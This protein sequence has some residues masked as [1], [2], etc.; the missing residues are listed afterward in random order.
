MA[1]ATLVVDLIL[2][3]GGFESDMGRA[4][5]T[6]K[7]RLREIETAAKQAGKVIGG[8][9]IVGAGLAAAAMKSAIDRADEL[10]NSS[11]KLGVT[12]EALST[13]SY[14]AKQ[15]DLEFSDLE[16]AMVRLAK[17]QSEADKG[18]D[19]QVGLFKALGVEFRNADGSLRNTADLIRE[20]AVVLADLPN[21]ADKAAVMVDLFGKTG[22]A[23]IPFITNLS[24]A[25]QR[26]RDLGL[27]VSGE[28]AAAADQFKDLLGDLTSMTGGL[29]SEIAAE[30]LPSLI[31]MVEKFV[32]FVSKGSGIKT[33]AFNIATGIRFVGDAALATTDLIN[34]LV[35]G[36]MYLWAK[37]A[38]F[39]HRMARNAIP[40]VKMLGIGDDALGDYASQAEAAK[41][42]M[43]DALAAASGRFEFTADLTTPFPKPGAGG[44]ESET[45]SKIQAW[46]QEQKEADA[47]KA[48]AK[49]AS[50]AAREAARAAKEAER[51]RLE[52]A[53]EGIAAQESLLGIWQSQTSELGGPLQQ[54]AQEYADQMLNILMAEEKLIAAGQMDEVQTVRLIEARE[55][56]AE[57][58]EKNKKAIEDQLS[59]GE[60]LL[61]QLEFELALMRMGNAERMTAIQLRGLEADEVAKFGA[62]IKS[63]NEE[64]VRIE[65]YDN[66]REAVANA[67]SEGFRSGSVKDAIESFASALHNAISDRLAGDITDWLLGPP[68]S[69]SG[70]SAGGGFLS[71]LSSL[72]GGGKAHGGPVSGSKFYEVGENNRPEMFYSGGKSFLIPGNEGRVAPIGGGGGGPINVNYN[73]RVDARTPLQTANEIDRRQRLAATRNY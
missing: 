44:G 58:Y 52:I 72:W 30:L 35:N 38:E 42:G 33:A 14:A 32:D 2:K 6:A 59:P 55:H 16:G 22:A 23:L 63:K 73:R 50:E 70:G 34:G 9:F 49:A 29:A 15:A 1:L 11:L 39:G 71:W 8:A 53:K 10:H 17:A 60:E 12:A 43:L 3:A 61:D 24:E 54:A 51:E 4:S 5:K 41:Q 7:K 68:G 27:E 57:I 18:T 47:A 31:G 45:S 69:D 20:V 67:I 25:E 36:L 46:R 37:S 28:T 40:L 66:V 21:G 56:A 64:I 26:A 19:K 13:L 65:Q 48:R 62:Q